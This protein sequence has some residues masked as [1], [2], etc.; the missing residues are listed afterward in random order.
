MTN[1]D[2]AAI[3]ALVESGIR[4][5]RSDAAAWLIGA[6]IVANDELLDKLNATIEQIR[7]LR[8][9]AQALVQG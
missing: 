7:Q 1:D 3:D 5:T 4:S 2:L 8:T 9:S 6:G